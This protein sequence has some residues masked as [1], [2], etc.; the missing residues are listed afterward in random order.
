M[1]DDA[2]ALEKK[3]AEHIKK[4]ADRLSRELKQVQQNT[5]TQLEALSWLQGRLSLRAQLPPLRGWAA[6]PD[7]LLRLHSHI[8]AAKPAVVVEFGSGA[9]TLVMADALRQNGFGQLISIDHSGYYGEQTRATL[10]AEHLTSWVD[11]RIG[12]LQPWEGEHPCPE[13]SDKPPYW[14]PAGLLD[15]IEGVALIVVDGPPGATCP[16]SRY[17]AVPALYDRMAPAVQVWMDDAKRKDE[18]TIC[19]HWAQHYP[20][21]VTFLPLEKGLGILKRP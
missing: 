2:A 6:S 10:D 20:L 15:G 13:D 3:L 16:F 1:A 17:P 11:L 19:E 7:V 14:Y 18:K 5:Y 4:G 9:S 21:E 12:A 8:M